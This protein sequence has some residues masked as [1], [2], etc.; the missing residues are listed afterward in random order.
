M[1][2]YIKSE[3]KLAMDEFLTGELNAERVKEVE[4]LTA[5]MLGE[6][7]AEMEAYIQYEKGNKRTCCALIRERTQLRASLAKYQAEE[8]SRENMVAAEASETD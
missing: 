3:Y 1:T 5:L 6:Y 2:G 4:Y 7:A 8:Q